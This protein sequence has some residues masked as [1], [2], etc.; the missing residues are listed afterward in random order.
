MYEM[1]IKQCFK[2]TKQNTMES[3]KYLKNAFFIDSQCF[4]GDSP[5]TGLI[6][7]LAS[8]IITLGDQ[9][10]KSAS[11]VQIQTLTGQS[12]HENYIKYQIPGSNTSFVNGC[13][14]D[15]GNVSETSRNEY[16][17]NQ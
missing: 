4:G 15:L 12:V 3:Q 13:V 5:T 1:E 16:V 7:D 10:H 14:E 9:I 2:T 8:Q 11:R 6:Y 17:D